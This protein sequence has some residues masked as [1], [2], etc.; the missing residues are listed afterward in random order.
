MA[1]AVLVLA[2]MHLRALFVVL[3]SMLVPAVAHAQ[4]IAVANQTS[5]ARIDARGE[6]VAKRPASLTPEGV[7]RRDCDDDQK[8]RFP[9]TLSGF[10]ANATLSAWVSVAGVDCAQPPNRANGLCT[11]LELALPLMPTLAVDVPVRRLVASAGGNSDARACGKVDLTD[12]DVQFMY[13][14]PGGADLP[15]VKTSVAITVD[16]VGPEPPKEV[17][18]RPGNKRVVVEW[19]AF[20]NV[21]GVTGVSAFCDASPSTALRAGVEPTSELDAKMRCAEVAGGSATSIV[22]SEKANEKPIANDEAVV[23][24]V[25]ATDSFGNRGPLS[26][27]ATTTPS[28]FAEPDSSEGGGGGC[29]AAP[30]RAN[31]AAILLVLGVIAAI[32]SSNRKRAARRRRSG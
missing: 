24:A 19:D 18:V 11:A 12:L 21:A 4:S 6:P 26:S 25:S 9:L 28:E 8:I 30:A 1:H 14:V 29:S 27:P 5:L 32:S 23:V 3:P 22:V 13:F 20:Q 17:R 10:Q 16:T 15:A 7:S 31:P 2:A